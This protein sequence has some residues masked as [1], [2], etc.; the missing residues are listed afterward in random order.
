MKAD[1]NTVKLMMAMQ[2][3]WS[4]LN[5]SKEESYEELTKVIDDS[6]SILEIAIN[7]FITRMDERSP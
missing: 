1:A 2:T 5:T 7:N 4:K 6:R 3:V